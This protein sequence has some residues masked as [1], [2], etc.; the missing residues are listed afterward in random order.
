ML[1][2]RY[3]KSRLGVWI[4]AASSAIVLAPTHA[5]E[6][7]P[8]FDQV[9]TVVEAYFSKQKDHLPGDLISRKQVAAVCDEIAR[10]GWTIADRAELE[11]RALDDGSLLMTQLRSANGKKFM[12]QAG[13]MSMG[14]DQL[15]RLSQLPQGRST[16]DRMMRDPQG[17]KMLEFFSAT[18]NGQEMLK[19]MSRGA[20]GKSDRPTGKIYTVDE[21]SSALAE[22]YKAAASAPAV[23]NGK[24]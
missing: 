3:G 7:L 19:K 24:R 21:L 5:A 4:V 15:D 20:A 13:A 18:S 16:L 23:K 17:G 9:Q 6:T 10:L 2:S 12:R 22:S 1:N 14:Y 11:K 8:K